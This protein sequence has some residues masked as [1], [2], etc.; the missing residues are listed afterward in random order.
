MHD[1][2]QKH[3]L[4][5][6]FA[7]TE[8]IGSRDTNKIAAYSVYMSAGGMINISFPLCK[9]ILDIVYTSRDTS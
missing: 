9:Q 3:N 8:F 2:H 1:T 5:C 4:V 7:H 6:R